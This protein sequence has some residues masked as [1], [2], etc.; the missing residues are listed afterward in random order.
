ME[1]LIFFKNFFKAFSK[2]RSLEEK[3]LRIGLVLATAL[4]LIA[5]LAPYIAPYNP[6]EMY[7]G[8]PYTPPCP[9]HLF[10][11]DSMGRD[12]FSRVIYGTRSALMVAVISAAFAFAIGIPLGLISGYVGGVFDRVV[13][14]IMDALYAFPSLVMALAIAVAL[15]P[16]GSASV[17]SI[18]LNTA[19]A[20]SVVYIPS[21]F[22]VIRATTLSVKENLYVEAAKAIGA[23]P[24]K[25]VLK[26]IAPNAVNPAIPIICMNFADAILTAAGLSFLGIG[27]PPFYPD[28]GVD[29]SK[30]W[31][32]IPNGVWWTSFFPGLMIFLATLAF[33]LI[34]DALVEYLNPRKERLR[35]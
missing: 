25:I 35:P 26:Y 24:F 28:W 7:I 17:F 16:G 18:I 5:V 3:M 27:L 32:D 9:Q 34:S 19:I 10:G 14:L 13:T 11:T 2:V 4:I 33:M 30:G 12:V 6:I 22:R 29:V 21:Y 1:S 8:A 31:K 20:I 23:P 15:N